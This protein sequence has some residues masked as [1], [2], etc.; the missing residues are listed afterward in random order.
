MQQSV[1]KVFFAL[2]RY[3]FSSEL[4]QEI[5]NLIS[6]ELLKPLFNLS[7]CHDLAHLVGDAL[8]QKGLISGDS[9]EEKLFL[10]ERNL[11]ILRHEQ[12]QYE[13]EQICK[14]F[15][16]AKIPFI[17]LKGAVIKNYYKEPWLR[18]SCDIDILVKKEHLDLAIS[19]LKEN[20]NYK[21]NLI[22]N[23]D[24]QLYSQTNVHLELHYSLLARETSAELTKILSSVWDNAVKKTDYLYEMKDDFFYL[25]IISHVANHLKWGGCGVRPFIDIYILNTMIDFCNE[26]RENLLKMSGLLTFAN[27][28]KNLSDVWLLN[29]EPDQLSVNLE[30]YVLS[31]GVYGSLENNVAVSKVKTPSKFKY[32]LSRIFLPY[33]SLKLRYNR[34]QKYPILYPYYLVKRWFRIIFNKGKREKAILEYNEV[35]KVD[36]ENQSDVKSLLDNLQI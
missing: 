36:K 28:V 30:K 13:Y 34:L 2:I 5:K 19:A 10:H 20:L 26:D 17:P 22:G 7:K 31:G 21:C 3:E 27:A 35:V 9:E 16:Q 15:E 25:Y 23:H 12:M 1:E 6:K 18:T 33:S 29:K 8:V 32:L 14:T 11:A 24:A 4:S